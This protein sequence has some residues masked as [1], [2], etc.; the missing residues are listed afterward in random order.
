MKLFAWLTQNYTNHVHI[1]YLFVLPRN[2]RCRVAIPLTFNF[3][4]DATLS[5][6]ATDRTTTLFAFFHPS[7]RF[8]H[9]RFCAIALWQASIEY[10]LC[11]FRSRLVSRIRDGPMQ[12]H[13]FDSRAWNRILSLTVMGKVQPSWPDRV[14]NRAVV[15]RSRVTRTDHLVQDI[16]D[17]PSLDL[18]FGRT[19]SRWSPIAQDGTSSAWH[20]AIDSPIER[21]CDG[22]SL[23]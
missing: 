2:Q 21:G 23:L 18:G 10:D 3:S 22:P 4:K 17:T 6:H 14:R 11:S 1:Y 9:F 19:R 15:S 12:H 8:F 5:T 13:C 7:P 16:A 20:G